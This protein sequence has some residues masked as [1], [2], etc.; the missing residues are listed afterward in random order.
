MRQEG[1]GLTAGYIPDR[2]IFDR[3]AGLSCRRAE[4]GRS[5][6]NQTL[7]YAGGAQPAPAAAYL[8]ADTTRDAIGMR[9]PPAA[10]YSAAAAAPAMAFR[11]AGDCAR[12]RPPVLGVPCKKASKTAAGEGRHQDMDTVRM[13]GLRKPA[14]SSAR[15]DSSSSL[16]RKNGGPGGRA[17]S[18]SP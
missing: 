13:D 8:T 15:S 2:E 6:R 7:G 9:M 17:T 4:T 16:K 5:R 14:A 18:G 10:A 3:Q 12:R 1:I 11:F